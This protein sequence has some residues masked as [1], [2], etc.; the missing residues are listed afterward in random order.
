VGSRHYVGAL[1][2]QE[3]E[4]IAAMLNFDMV[5]V[6]DRPMVG[7]FAAP[8]SH[9]WDVLIKES[10]LITNTFCAGAAGAA[11]EVEGA[12]AFNMHHVLTPDDALP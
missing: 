8:H 4:R 9:A 6:G 1:G 11:N 7:G 12:A 2:P 5:G 10:P 3:R